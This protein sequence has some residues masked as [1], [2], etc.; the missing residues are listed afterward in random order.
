MD[1]DLSMAPIVCDSPAVVL[2][3]R[4][5]DP[6][7]QGLP[8]DSATSLF[9]LDMH[10]LP[11]PLSKA[12]TRADPCQPEGTHASSDPCGPHD[13]PMCTPWSKAWVGPGAEDLGCH[14]AVR[15]NPV[16]MIISPDEHHDVQQQARHCEEDFVLYSAPL[17]DSPGSA[18]P[19]ESPGPVSPES[20]AQKSILPNSA[21]GFTISPS[22][23]PFYGRAQASRSSVCSVGVGPVFELGDPSTEQGP[24]HEE[25]EVDDVDALN[26]L[27]K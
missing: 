21:P 1:S 27:L 4:P 8:H 6:F 23:V 11:S 3:H 18:K 5:R 2:V 22:P 16:G 10:C 24:V 14:S 19:A 20:P 25:V 26:L 12:A 9:R 17:M 7:A 13:T 15:T